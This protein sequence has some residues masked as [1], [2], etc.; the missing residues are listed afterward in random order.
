MVVVECDRFPMDGWK[1]GG[2]RKGYAQN[3]NLVTL[4]FR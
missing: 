1:R 3:L 2:L 4:S